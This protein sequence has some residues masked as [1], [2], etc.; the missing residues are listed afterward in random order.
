MQRVSL[1]W[2]VENLRGLNELSNLDPS[3]KGANAWVSLYITRT[4]LSGMLQESVYSRHF[5][6]SKDK[7]NILL[8]TLDR[9]IPANPVPDDFQVQEA[10]IWTLKNQKSQL[11]IVLLSEMATLP[12]YLITPKEAYDLEKLIDD[13]LS[14]F[15][16]AMLGKAPETYW[17]AQEAGRCLAFERNTACGF[18]AFRVVEAVLRR[19]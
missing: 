18:H 19:Y 17:D 9:L 4:S 6:V 10:D 5:K 14:L 16:P 15:P 1:S 2:V 8:A 3:H 12:V 7:A 11:E 13:G